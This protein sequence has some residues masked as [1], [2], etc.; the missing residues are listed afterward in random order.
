MS[1]TG[2]LVVLVTMELQLAKQQWHLKKKKDLKR[3]IAFRNHQSRAD[4][5]DGTA[6]RDAPETGAWQSGFI[7]L[8]TPED[9]P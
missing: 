9:L 7:C 4:G 1:V 8:F 3:K 6:A 5:S 2:F